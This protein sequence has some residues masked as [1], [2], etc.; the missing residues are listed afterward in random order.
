MAALTL[1]TIVEAGVT[2][3]YASAAGGGDTAKNDNGDV[4]LHVKNGSGGALTVTVTAQKTSAITPGMGSTTK[5]NVAVSVGAGS[6]EM[7]GPFAPLAFNNAS[8]NLAIT[9]SGVTSL[10]IAAI[11]LPRVA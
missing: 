3:S 8:G 6:E 10:T 11:K 4:F 9:Y 7:I 1:Q 5:S 2:P